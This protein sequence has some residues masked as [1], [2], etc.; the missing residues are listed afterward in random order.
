VK[1]STDLSKLMLGH[2]P[3]DTVKVTWVDQSG[4]SHSASVKLASGPPA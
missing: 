2:H 3:G 4:A 1:S